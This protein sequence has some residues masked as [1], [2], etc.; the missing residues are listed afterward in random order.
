MGVFLFGGVGRGAVKL[1]ESKA[2]LS[3]VVIIPLG[4]LEMSDK[5]LQLMHHVV[6]NLLTLVFF[7]ILRLAVVH[8]QQIVPEGRHHKE[9][10]H[11]TVHVADAT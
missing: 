6:I 10:L 2:E 11:H 1:L 4:K 7:E 5:L 3:R 8:A 9:L